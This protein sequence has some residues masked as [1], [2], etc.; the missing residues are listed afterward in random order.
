MSTNYYHCIFGL[1]EANKKLNKKFVNTF[2]S[3]SKL[4]TTDIYIGRSGSAVT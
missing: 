4:Q 3:S 2:V 1:I